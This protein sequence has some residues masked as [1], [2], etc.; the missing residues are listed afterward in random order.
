MRREA[1]HEL[2][3]ARLIRR[4]MDYMVFIDMNILS[5]VII[6][7]DSHILRKSIFLIFVNSKVIELLVAW[8]ALALQ[9]IIIIF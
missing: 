6:L 1:A 9:I 3:K 5:N 2:K 7:I 4:F 8:G